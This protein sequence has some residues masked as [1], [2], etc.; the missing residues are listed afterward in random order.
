VLI[1]EVIYLFGPYSPY[2]SSS[3][4]HQEK[5]R[6]QVGSKKRDNPANERAYECP[7]FLS[8]FHRRYGRFGL[9]ENHI[10]TCLSVVIFCKQ[11]GV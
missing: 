11:A 7:S 8:D 1:F 4:H 6:P 9:S 10:S 3:D 5:R 2:T